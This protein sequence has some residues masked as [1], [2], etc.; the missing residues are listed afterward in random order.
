MQLADALMSAAC[1]FI[2][3]LFFLFYLVFAAVLCCEME[4]WIL[5]DH[6]QH[7]LQRGLKTQHFFAAPSDSFKWKQRWKKAKLV[8]LSQTLAQGE[9]ACFTSFFVVFFRWIIEG[10]WKECFLSSLSYLFSFR[11]SAYYLAAHHFV[12]CSG[13]GS[14]A[15]TA[16]NDTTASNARFSVSNPD[17]WPWWGTPASEEI[18]LP[19]PTHRPRPTSHPSAITSPFNSSLEKQLYTEN[20]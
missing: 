20:H 16:D 3:W 4:A 5:F 9:C 6:H 1:F 19:W 17:I 10:D 18:F 15:G 11:H 13:V 14:G 7:P 2:F 8:L 12:K